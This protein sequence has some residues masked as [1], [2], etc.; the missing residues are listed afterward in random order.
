V[1]PEQGKAEGAGTSIV[2]CNEGRVQIASRAVCNA[3]TV[4]TMGRGLMAV[5]ASV[6]LMNALAAK[7]IAVR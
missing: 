2:A 1:T 4:M 6:K 7:E 5:R 3:M